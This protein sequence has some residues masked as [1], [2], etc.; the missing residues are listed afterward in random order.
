MQKHIERLFKS[1]RSIE[2]EPCF[3][4]AQVKEKIIDLTKATFESY[5]KRTSAEKLHTK[6]FALR[7]N[8][9]AGH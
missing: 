3:T 6:I 2:I 4:P 5:I 1:A 8:F 7:L 9:S